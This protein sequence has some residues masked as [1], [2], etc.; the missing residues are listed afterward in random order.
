M[1]REQKLQFIKEKTIEANPE[2]VINKHAQLIHQDHSVEY[3][4]QTRPIRLADILLVISKKHF[5]KAEHIFLK[6]IAEIELNE[7]WEKIKDVIRR[8]D[9]LHDSLSEQSEETIDFLC[10]LFPDFEKLR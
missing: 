6:E 2:I 5:P 8:W 1:N 9:L 3:F 7:F 4:E 10:S